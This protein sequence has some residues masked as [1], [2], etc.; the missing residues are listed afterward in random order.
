[1]NF[2][3]TGDPNGKGLP[4]WPAVSDAGA[5]PT[6]IGDSKDTPDPQRLTMYDALHAK[7]LA[8][9]RTRR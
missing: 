4:A 3:R 7:I 6:V 2:A 1:M 5:A 8:D 9:L